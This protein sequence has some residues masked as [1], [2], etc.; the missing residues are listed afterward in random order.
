MGV[1]IGVRIIF[2]LGSR[3]EEFVVFDSK[4]ENRVRVRVKVG[5]RI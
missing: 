5:L 4:S 3:L 1:G 2:A